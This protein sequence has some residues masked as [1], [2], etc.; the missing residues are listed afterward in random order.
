M[1]KDYQKA[2]FAFSC[3]NSTPCQVVVLRT[4][5]KDAPRAFAEIRI[6]N[7]SYSMNFANLPQSVVFLTKSL[8]VAGQL[9]VLSG[10]K[11]HKLK[12]EF[13]G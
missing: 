12:S 3:S 4:C 5:Q 10:Y 13:E 7:N 1:A 2:S 6:P 11:T 8:A 9:N